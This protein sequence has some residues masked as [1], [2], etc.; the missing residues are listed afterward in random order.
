[1]LVPP[2]E[3]PTDP[4]SPVNSEEAHF[5]SLLRLIPYGPRTLA[6]LSDGLMRTFYICGQQGWRSQ[7]SPV[8]TCPSTPASAYLPD[9]VRPHPHLSCP[10]YLGEKVIVF[11]TPAL[12]WAR[13]LE[14]RSE[15]D[16]ILS[17]LF[18]PAPR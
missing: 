14:K 2:L 16:L 17:S 13:C 18:T 5:C 6:A 15:D 1:M 10:I 9:P 4:L 3:S 7:L 12:P 11:L 8:P